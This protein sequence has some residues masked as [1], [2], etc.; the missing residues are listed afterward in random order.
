[1]PL[2][3]LQMQRSTIIIQDKGKYMIYILCAVL[4][5]FMWAVVHGGNKKKI[6]YNISHEDNA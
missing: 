5:L 1:M 4:F 3:V 2:G 6:R